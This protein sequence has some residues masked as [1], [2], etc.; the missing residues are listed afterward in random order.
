MPELQAMAIC[1]SLFCILYLPCIAANCMA[2][3][4]MEDGN[5]YYLYEKINLWELVLAFQN[6]SSISEN[7]A[8][9]Q[10]TENMVDDEPIEQHASSVH[11]KHFLAFHLHFILSGSP[12]LKCKV[13]AWN[14]VSMSSY[15]IFVAT[16]Y[17]I[18][19]W[20]LLHSVFQITSGCMKPNIS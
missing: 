9:R 20:I 15:H 17:G 6:L 12:K 3:G 18:R 2:I 5:A 1:N 4:F 8:L 14:L 10:Q 7:P 13:F 19:W 11:Q 16:Q